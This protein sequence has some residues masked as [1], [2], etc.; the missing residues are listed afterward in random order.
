MT[1]YVTFHHF[2]QTLATFECIYRF[3][4]STVINKEIF[5]WVADEFNINTI[6]ISSIKTAWYIVPQITRSW[7][8][9]ARTH[10]SIDQTAICMLVLSR[11]LN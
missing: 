4:L 7:N 11:S 5:R 6:S 8:L 2:I 3:K 9:T 1:I 10:R